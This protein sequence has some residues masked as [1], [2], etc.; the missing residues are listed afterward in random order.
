MSERLKNIHLDAYDDEARQAAR[1]A[2]SVR[3]HTS[4]W[5]AVSAELR[6]RRSRDLTADEVEALKTARAIIKATL[7]GARQYKTI[8]PFVPLA[9]SVLSK[10]T[11]G[12]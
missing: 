2:D 4:D 6:A 10:L 9:L 7:N 11:R 12:E 8:N 5:L 1:H 3:I